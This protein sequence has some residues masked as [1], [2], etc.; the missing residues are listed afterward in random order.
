M[1]RLFNDPHD[2][3]AEMLRG[4]AAAS[5]RWVR[6]APGGV[7]RST[8][9]AE[10]TVSLVIGGGSGHFP[11]F[12]GLV[13]PGLAHGAAMGNV[14]ASPSTQQILSVARACQQG[15][16]ILFSYG[17]YAGDVLNFDQAQAIL[18]REGI[19]ART[20]V[21][22]DDIFS[23]AATEAENRRGIAG[24][25]TVFKIAGAAAEAGADLDEVERLARLAN[26][27]TRSIGVA[28]SGCTLPGAAEPLFEVPPGRMAIGLGIHGEPGID[29]IDMPTAGELAEILVARL[30][31]EVPDGAGRQSA[32]VVPILNG[33]GTIKYEELYLLYGH[34]D[35]LLSRAGLEVVSPEVGEFC[36]SF[37]MAGLSLTLLWLDDELEPLWSAPCDTAAFR[38]GSISGHSAVELSAADEDSAQTTAEAIPPATPESRALAARIAEAIGL[39][40]AALDTAAD[41][42]GRIDQVAGDGDHGIG[43]QRGSEAAARTARSLIADGA[44]AGTVLMRAAAAWSDAGGG[45][46]GVIW[47]RIISGLATA[48]EDSSVPRLHDVAETVAQVSTAVR[49]FGGAEVGDKTLVDALVPFADAFT[50]SLPGT[51]ATDSGSLRRTLAAATREGARAAGT[52][53]EATADIVAKKG[54]SRS[55]GAKSLGTPDPGAVSLAL[56][57]RTLA[58]FLTE[59]SPPHSSHPQPQHPNDGARTAVLTSQEKTLS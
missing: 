9:A 40:A 41:E 15:R 31:H 20:V 37:D 38:R 24:D 29:E 19:D 52:A 6:A 18:R 30:L 26:D 22:T 49:E 23:A 28:F 27:R 32:R 44:G 58:D 13:G 59:T 35:T 5:A 45:T 2:F 55:H 43:M 50:S 11:A 16:G 1:T 46:S 14:F 42:L 54:R 8:R 56:I 36:T 48:C 25:L 53:A 34:I 21:V 51:E 39:V 47:G 4:F 12:S 33:L 3:V 10:P 7:V 57:A 17:N